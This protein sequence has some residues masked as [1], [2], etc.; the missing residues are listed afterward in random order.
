[1]KEFYMLLFLYFR[2]LQEYNWNYDIAAAVFLDL[3]NQVRVYI[4]FS[5]FLFQK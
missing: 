3:Q 4:F 5:N 2:C 1:M